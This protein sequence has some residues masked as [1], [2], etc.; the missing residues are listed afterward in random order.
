VQNRNVPIAFT[1]AVKII[2]RFFQRGS[3]AF[4]V[5]PLSVMKTIFFSNF[6]ISNAALPDFTL[7][8]KK[9]FDAVL[10]DFLR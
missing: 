2:F 6:L 10:P 3:A 5:P 7:M 1:P 9:I 8:E 4:F